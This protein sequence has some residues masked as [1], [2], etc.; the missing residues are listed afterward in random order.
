[1]AD[2]HELFLHVTGNWD[3]K[4][5]INTVRE[6]IFGRIGHAVRVAF[7]LGKVVPHDQA[8]YLEACEYQQGSDLKY[9]GE[10]RG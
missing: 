9:S 8:E 2:F 6:A 1:V 5:G 7:S 4:G 10:T 3:L